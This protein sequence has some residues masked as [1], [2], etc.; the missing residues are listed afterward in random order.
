LFAVCCS[1]Q[2][3]DITDGGAQVNLKKK[4]KKNHT[5]EVSCSVISPIAWDK[6]EL[7]PWLNTRISGWAPGANICRQGEIANP[8][9]RRARGVGNVRDA[10]FFFPLVQSWEMDP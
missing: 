5:S 10:F 6:K 2:S 8:K 1:S 7:D 4:K 9:G 3:A